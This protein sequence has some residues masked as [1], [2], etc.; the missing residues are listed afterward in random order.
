MIEFYKTDV[1]L[2]LIAE[3]I[4]NGTTTFTLPS[5]KK[6]KI[7]R[8]MK[9]FY[10]HGTKCSKCGLEGIFFMGS[11]VSD[12]VDLN[13]F[14]LIDVDAEGELGIHPIM[15][16][17]DHI[18]PLSRGGGNHQENLQVMCKKCNGEKGCHL[19]KRLEFGFLF[20]SVRDYV[21]TQYPDSDKRNRFLAEF[22]ELMKPYRIPKMNSVLCGSKWEIRQYLEYVRSKYGYKVPLRKVKVV[23][24]PDKQ[25]CYNDGTNGHEIVVFL[26]SSKHHSKGEE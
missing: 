12:T 21:T 18:V 4:T 10:F 3:A 16:T 2:Q 24:K 15:L 19:D 25:S 17:T 5:G 20:R 14:G 26:P 9:A 7:T 22:K 8:K 6:A 13:L 11:V 1:V 23:Y